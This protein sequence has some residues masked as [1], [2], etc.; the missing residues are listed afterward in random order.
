MPNNNTEI[1]LKPGREKSLKLRNFWVFSG[2][3]AQP[4]QEADKPAA[5]VNVVSDRGE[6]LA[7]A[8]YSPKSQISAK[9]WSFLQEK[10]NRAF[11]RRKIAA[12]YQLRQSAMI[13]QCAS[14]YRL[15]AAEGDALPGIIIDLYNDFLV[16]QLLSAPADMM[17]DEIVG[18][19]LDLFPDI[20]GIYERS[21][22]DVRRKE[23]LPMR[24]PSQLYEAFLEGI[25]L[26]AVLWIYSARPRPTGRVA[27]LF[28]LLYAIFRSQVVFSDSESSDDTVF[29]DVKEGDVIQVPVPSDSQDAIF[30][31]W[32][33]RSSGQYLSAEDTEYT[34]KGMGA[35]FEALYI[36]LEADEISTG[37]YDVTRL[38]AGVQIPLTFSLTN[39]GSEDVRDVDITVSCDS[40][41][42]RLIN[43]EA[44]LRQMRSGHDYT[45]KNVILVISQ[46]CPSGEE[47]PLTVTMEDSDGNT[48]SSTFTLNVK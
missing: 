12:A 4:P 36:K 11:F 39:S 35:S 42:A 40:S 14:A 24:H 37:P 15:V 6:F 31:G 46:D 9:V 38:P 33:D 3:I 26:F 10:I 47:I 16:I 1:R 30:E 28:A 23:G 29:T 8:G 18:A 43:T 45:L 25:V 41:H 32:Y 48:F 13:P 20:K 7:V 2:A 27:G 19:L 22:A 21:D 44:W 17:K 34:V 5:A